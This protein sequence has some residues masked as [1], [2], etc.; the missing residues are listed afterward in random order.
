ML[1]TQA[2]FG[3]PAPSPAFDKLVDD[4]FDFHFTHH[5][6]EGTAAG[7]H[8]YDAKLEDLS[9][10]SLQ[11][12]AAGLKQFLQKFQALDKS[13]FSATAAGDFD[14]LTGAIQSRLLDL[15]N[16]QMW[17]KDPDSYTGIASNSVFVIM[18]RNF[19]PQAERLRSVI[20]REKAIP[21]LFAAARHNLQDPPRVYTEVALQQLPDVIAFFRKDV[22]AA[23]S[24]VKD[25][26]LLAEFKASNNAVVVALQKYEDFLEDDLLPISHGDF[27]IGEE[28]F[29]KKLLYDEMVDIPLD[30]LLAIGYADL[31]RNQ[32]RLKEVAAQI[33][34][35]R[36]VQQ[37]LAGLQKDHPAPGKLLQTF[38]DTLGS[39][40]QFIAQKDIVTIPSQVPP[41]V[42]E[43]PPFERALTTASM[44]TPGAYET[45]ATE[46][47]FNVTLPDPRWKPAKIEEWM[48]SFNRGT[49]ISTAIH[50][51]YPGHYLQFLWVQE[52][53]SKTRK[54]FY[55]TSNAEGWAHYTE[56]MMLDEGYGNGDPKLRL[57]QIIDALLRDARFIAGIEMHTGKKTLE[58]AREFFIQQGYQVAPV[59]EEESRRG[60]S[61]PTYLYYTLGKLQILKLREDYRRKR[62]DAFSL[63]QFHDEFMRQGSVPMSIIRKAMLGDDGPTL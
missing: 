63:H 60:T 5:P 25:P 16:I 46:A 35:K 18:R 52:A 26:Q 37:V 38:R 43:T 27:R 61:D 48:Q 23:F 53:P 36:S 12:E 21:A 19:A 3:S 33:D 56:Q 20:A 30:K 41:I 34:P 45:K 13:Q 39:L 40:T 17:R 24:E 59:A 47:L 42:E 57:G 51:V 55:C 29:R 2:S 54:L 14:F 62:G 22:P 7:F 15:E 44:D 10:V 6:T 49:I 28:N 9:T 11:A 4:F 1:W 32:Q 58:Q 8:Q 50:E 31:H